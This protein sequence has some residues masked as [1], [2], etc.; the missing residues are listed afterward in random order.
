M[1]ALRAIKE[2]EFDR[3]MAKVSDEDFREMSGR[4]RARAGTADASTRGRRRVP[5]AD[6]AGSG[7]A[8]GGEGC[9]GR[10]RCA[11]CAS[12]ATANDADA[13]FCK[14]CGDEADDPMLQGTEV[15]LL[16][17]SVPVW[18]RSV[19]AVWRSSSVR[20]R[21]SAQIAMPDAEAD[22]GHSPAG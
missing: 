20:D 5:G 2:L 16:R 4:L 11:T 19:L 13:Q 1:L 15:E 18:R 8:A 17:F 3:A 6:R 22:V 10:R 21:L 14:S 12:C 7:E 9:G